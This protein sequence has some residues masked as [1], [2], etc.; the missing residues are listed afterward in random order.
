MQQ[1][2]SEGP[3]SAALDRPPLPGI[4]RVTNLY[5]SLP[6][7]LMLRDAAAKERVPITRLVQDAARE[8]LRRRGILS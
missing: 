1:P 8:E 5:W 7:Y 2:Q 3:S 6:D 4:R